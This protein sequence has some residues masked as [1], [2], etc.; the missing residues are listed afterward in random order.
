MRVT[1]PLLLIIAV[2]APTLSLA[3]ASTPDHKP[4]R[5]VLVGDLP[6]FKHR[7]VVLDYEHLK[8]NPCNDIII[9]SVTP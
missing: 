3:E 6:V 1:N 9:P 5:I 4:I 7:G 2:V 8:Y